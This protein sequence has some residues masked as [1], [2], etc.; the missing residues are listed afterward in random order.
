[1]QIVFF[2]RTRAVMV[3]FTSYSVTARLHIVVTLAAE[4]AFSGTITAT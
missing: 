2:L 1:M 3:E 4:F